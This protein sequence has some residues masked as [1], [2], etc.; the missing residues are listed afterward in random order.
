[1]YLLMIH[2]NVLRVTTPSSQA[3]KERAV[4]V[5][6]AACVARLAAMETDT[7][8]RISRLR[9]R[10]YDVV[11]SFCHSK[12]DDDASLRKAANKLLHG[13]TMR[14]REGML[15]GDDEIEEVFRTIEKELIGLSWSIER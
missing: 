5:S 4:D 2:M 9:R 1:M 11:V 15:T 8:E 14:L 6:V 13:P 7:A 10:V 3:A 12:G